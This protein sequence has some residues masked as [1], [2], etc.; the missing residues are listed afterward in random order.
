[1]TVHNI[2]NVKVSAPVSHCPTFKCYKRSRAFGVA[3]LI[4]LIVP[5]ID[6]TASL[7]VLQL[8]CIHSHFQL[9]DIRRYWVRFKISNDKTNW[10]YNIVD[11]VGMFY[12]DNRR[13][14]LW[15]SSMHSVHAGP[16]ACA[17]HND[18]LMD[19]YWMKWHCPT[20]HGPRAWHMLTIGYT[21][22]EH[23][24]YIADIINHWYLSHSE[25]PVL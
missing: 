19:A 16:A 7:S 5:S 25:Q 6:E 2:K 22:Y 14:T 21:M 1:M 24:Q 12:N 8:R 13:P 11:S 15:F 20:I 9:S 4:Q 18:E 17:C 23:R 3:L 10:A